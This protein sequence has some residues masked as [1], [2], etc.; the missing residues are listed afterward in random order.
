MHE[1]AYGLDDVS[2]VMGAYNEV[3]AIG[4]VLDD[5]EAATD[6]RAEAVV[7]DSSDD[8][9]AAVARD[10]G[11]TVVDQPPRGYGVA[12][13]RAL[14]EAT[15]PVRVTTDCDG[16]YPMDRIPDFLDLVNEGYDVVSGD[17]LYHGARTMPRVNRAGNHAFAAL[18]SLLS[19]RRL[20]DV[21][22]GMRAYHESV[23]ESI[24][25]TENTGLS[26]ELLIRPVMRG[27]R[28]REEPIDYDERIG[29]TKL[30]PFAGGRAIGGSILTVCAEERRRRRS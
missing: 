3:D 12:V 24:E 20:H 5:I 2:V 28:V 11:A 25:W 6:G 29:E 21:T 17:R 23:V 4:P 19:G 8:G 10:H 7:V 27:Y 26:A 22:T 1:R 15:T 13:S 16:T 18:A 30:D 9:T 14:R